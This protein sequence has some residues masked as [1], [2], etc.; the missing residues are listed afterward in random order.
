[1]NF[2]S[3]SQSYMRPVIQ[4]GVGQGSLPQRKGS[5]PT[6]IGFWR[7]VGKVL[8]AALL[9]VLAVNMYFAYYVSKVNES[10]I[11]ADNKRHELMDKNIGLRATKARLRGDEQFQKLAA[12]K[13][14]LYAHTK[15]QVGKF[16]RRKGYF[17]YL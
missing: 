9:L 10:I 17:I 14:S 13:L 8:L 4:V 15:G 16:D 12:E 1:M 3:T 6:S 7:P 11:A 2:H 5:L